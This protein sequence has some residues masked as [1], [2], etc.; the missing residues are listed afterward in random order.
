MASSGMDGSGMGRKIGI[1]SGIIFDS[2]G[3]DRHGQAWTGVE[4][5]GRARQGLAWVSQ[6]L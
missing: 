5:R 4:R 2:P 1:L 3:M 6:S